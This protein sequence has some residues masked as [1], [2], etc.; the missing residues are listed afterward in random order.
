MWQLIEMFGISCSAFQCEKALYGQKERE[1]IK[2]E[3]ENKGK[4]MELNLS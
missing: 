3:A 1:I 4:D 2:S